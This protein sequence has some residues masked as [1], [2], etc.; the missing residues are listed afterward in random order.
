MKVGGH[1]VSVSSLVVAMYDALLR[2]GLFVGSGR[3]ISEMMQLVKGYSFEL[4]RQPCRCSI[5]LG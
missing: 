2:F 3:G 1:T 4:G 5:R